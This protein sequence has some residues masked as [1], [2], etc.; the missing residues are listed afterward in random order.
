[1]EPVNIALCVFRASHSFAKSMQSETVVDA[2]IEDAAK[3]PV[4]LYQNDIMTAGF[5]SSNSGY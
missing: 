3:Q 5:I 4:T 2:L 1:M